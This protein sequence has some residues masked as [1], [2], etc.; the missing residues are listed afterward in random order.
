MIKGKIFAYSWG[1]YSEGLNNLK[2]SLLK[3][4]I[5]L[6]KIKRENSNFK[7]SKNK[8]ILNWGCSS[9]NFPEPLLE[10]N[11]LNKPSVLD[12]TTNKLYFFEYLQEIKK[13]GVSVCRTPSF[14]TDKEIATGW[15]F[16]GYFVCC[17][18]TLNG[19][20]GA[21]LVLAKESEDVV[22]APLYTTYIKKQDE[23]RVHFFNGEITD[24]QRK[25]I[26]PDFDKAQVN[27]QVRNYDNGFMFVRGGFDT[28]KDVLVEAQKAV[29]CLDMDFGALDIVYNANMQKAYVL[30]VNSAPGMEGQTSDNYA[31]SIAKLFNHE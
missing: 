21:G 14:T 25:A 30:E 18:T 5:N 22:E 7:P 11:V 6:I 2:E 27:F 23:Y 13:N 10:C 20:G 19:H 9:E 29:D 1:K 3:E 31:A 4:G 15:L 17:R 16:E 28:P 12:I 26:R 24:I 8:T